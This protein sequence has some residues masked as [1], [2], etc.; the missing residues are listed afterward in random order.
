MMSTLSIFTQDNLGH[1]LTDD[2]NIAFLSIVSGT[3]EVTMSLCRVE[4]M[5]KSTH[6][7]NKFYCFN[8]NFLVKNFY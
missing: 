5:W 1:T 6:D 8:V 3:W 2:L 4:M 7:V